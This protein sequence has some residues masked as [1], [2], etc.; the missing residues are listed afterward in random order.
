MHPALKL[1]SE[2]NGVI[3]H[4]VSFAR[5]VETKLNEKMF[6][7]FHDIQ[8]AVDAIWARPSK[9][10][11]QGL[12]IANPYKDILILSLFCITSLGTLNRVVFRRL[13]QRIRAEY[14]GREVYLPVKLGFNSMKPEEWQEV[15]GLALFDLES[16]IPA[17]IPT[18]ESI[19]G[20]RFLPTK[21]CHVNIWKY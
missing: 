20:M 11:S 3:I 2:P 17:S 12:Y 15:M 1:P 14:Y 21:P 9:V 10:R 13:L 18:F 7:E 5:G 8:S 4:P 6:C 16:P 19:T